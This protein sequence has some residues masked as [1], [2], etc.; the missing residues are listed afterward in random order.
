MRQDGCTDILSYDMQIESNPGQG[1]AGVQRADKK[2]L[3]KNSV[4]QLRRPRNKAE[5]MRLLD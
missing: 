1:W 2:K 4:E 5:S 3:G